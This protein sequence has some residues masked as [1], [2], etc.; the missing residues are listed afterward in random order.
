MEKEKHI[1][2]EKDGDTPR[3]IALRL[4]GK[5]E[6]LHEAPSLALADTLED[7]ELAI[8]LKRAHERF[9]QL[10]TEDF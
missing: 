5:Y 8:L 3:N 2:G 10:E 6:D 4:I 7:D 9:G 1:I